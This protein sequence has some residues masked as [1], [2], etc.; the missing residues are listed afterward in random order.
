[1]IY[2]Y[3]ALGGAGLFSIL[4][5]FIYKLMHSNKQL[6]TSVE[7]LK[8]DVK[9]KEWDDKIDGQLEKLTEAERDYHNAVNSSTSDADNS[10]GTK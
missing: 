8:T 10:K 1:M 4:A 6:S 5:G 2:I 3:A 9:F 7:K